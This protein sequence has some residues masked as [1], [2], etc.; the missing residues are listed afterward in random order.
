MPPWWPDTGAHRV[1][2]LAT[3]VL[4]MTLGGCKGSDALGP[5]DEASS[6]A[7]LPTVH[8]SA[9]PVVQ[10]VADGFVHPWGLAFL[11]TGDMLVTERGGQMWRV[12]SDGRQ[13]QRV[14][15]LPEVWAQGQGGL[16]DVVAEPGEQPWIY[17]SYAEAGAGPQAGLAGTA[18]ARGRLSGTA[19]R[20]VSVIFRQQPK[21]EG[22]NHFGSRLVL[23]PDQ[24]LFIGLGDRQRDNP[25][26]PGTQFAQNLATHLGKV[27]R[28]R[29]DGS[30]APG[31]PTWSVP[32]ALPEVWSL[33]HRNIQGAALH[34]T[35]GALWVAEHGPQGGDEINIA[36][37]GGNFGWPLRSYGCPYGSLP[38]EGCQ[39]GDGRHRPD[40]I[41]PVTY[42]V[43]L[44]M[45]PSGMA[46]Y[47]GKRYPGWEGSLFVGALR[48]AALWRLTVSASGVTGRESLYEDALGRIRDVRQS[49]DGLL[50]LLIDAEEG[51][52]LR[53]MP[54]S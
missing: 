53:L 35:T 26:S 12:S 8:S 21:V 24:S 9:L 45:A 5:A 2:V 7:P 46:F 22:G 6:P 31:N 52:L 28:I 11:S 33:G 14:S 20:D 27:V 41:E 25:R 43:P 47:T 3:L 29:R 17:W 42:W 51:R 44:S 10:T 23:G 30:A 36:Q 34:P 48:G 19:L 39:L 38:G 37:A 50:Y 32:Q 54:A 15:G 13:R 1:L 49:P 18:V 40:F 16:L 4:S